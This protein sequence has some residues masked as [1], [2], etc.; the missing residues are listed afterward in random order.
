MLTCYSRN[1]VYYYVIIIH[2]HR[3]A[4][5]VPSSRCKWGWLNSVSLI[6]AI[7]FCLRPLW[8][9]LQEYVE[10]FFEGLFIQGVSLLCISLN[11]K[12]LRLSL[13]PERCPGWV[14]ITS[15][16]LF[17]REGAFFSASGWVV[18]MFLGWAVGV[19]WRSVG[20]VD[21]KLSGF[22]HRTCLQLFCHRKHLVCPSSTPKFYRKLPFLSVSESSTSFLS[23]HSDV[24]A[25]S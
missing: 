7:P 4:S 10:L 12:Q 23:W 24:N 15:M 3:L 17:G 22:H 19:G 11:L 20:N 25:L 8:R 1:P 14:I 9:E 16:H 13:E 2:K 5:A 21:W 18:V 6:S